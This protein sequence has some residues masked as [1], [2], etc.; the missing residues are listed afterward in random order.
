MH[1][2]INILGQANVADTFEVALLGTSL[3]IAIEERMVWI[4]VLQIVND[5]P[6]L[7]DKP[8]VFKLKNRQRPEGIA[9]EVS[10]LLVT[11]LER[12]DDD[13]FNLKAHPQIR[14]FGDI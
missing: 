2:M 3:T 12:V 7:A 8:S 4:D 6:R 1:P 11:A 13:H 9:R 10:R 5:D 14:T